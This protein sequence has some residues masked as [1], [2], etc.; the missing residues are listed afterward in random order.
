VEFN[1]KQQQ[2]SAEELS[3]MVLV[4]M[5][6]QYLNKKI[7]HAVVTITAYTQFRTKYGNPTYRAGSADDISRWSPSKG[8]LRPE[9]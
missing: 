7:N 5:R 4:K 8:V 2:Y 3:S 1:S 6:E 9:R